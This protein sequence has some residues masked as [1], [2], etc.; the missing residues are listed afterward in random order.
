MCFQSVLRKC[1]NRIVD[2]VGDWIGSSQKL[3]IGLKNTE[4]DKKKK[5][6]LGNRQETKGDKRQ[7]QVERIRLELSFRGLIRFIN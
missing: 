4:S 7:D 1:E 3:I 5:K 6:K 2:Q